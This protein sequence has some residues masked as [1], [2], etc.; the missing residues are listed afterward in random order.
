[1]I[2]IRAAI[3]FA[4]LGILLTGIGV[5]SHKKEVK[6]IGIVCV[7]IVV[8]GMASFYLYTF[9]EMDRQERSHHIG[10]YTVLENS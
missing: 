4:I 10:K 8:I 1:M 3:C 9:C 7:S 2:L 6:I 5:L